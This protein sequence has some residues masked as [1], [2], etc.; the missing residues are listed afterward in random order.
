M[1]S[2]LQHELS[3]GSGTTGRQFPLLTCHTPHSRGP[4]SASS[5]L[6]GDKAMAGFT[7][8]AHLGEG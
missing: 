7:V 5:G 3:P 8:C 4:A 2:Q 1:G 6:Q